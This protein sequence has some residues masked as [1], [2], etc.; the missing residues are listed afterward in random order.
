MRPCP[1]QTSAPNLILS[2]PKHIPRRCCKQILPD[3]GK[4]AN[5]YGYGGQMR[6]ACC[7]RALSLKGEDVLLQKSAGLELEES[8]A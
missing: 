8:D 7:C 1:L 4:A 3:G 2:S 5:T 6:A